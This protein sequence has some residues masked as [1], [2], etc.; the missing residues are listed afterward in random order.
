MAISIK[1]EIARV[2]ESP[3]LNPREINTPPPIGGPLF[4]IDNIPLSQ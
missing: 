2:Q 4:T 1:T 3:S